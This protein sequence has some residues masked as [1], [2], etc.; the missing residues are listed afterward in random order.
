MKII[1]SV[2][3][4]AI[5]AITSLAVAPTNASSWA[6]VISTWAV[7]RGTSA[8]YEWGWPA[9]FDGSVICTT[10][11]GCIIT[12]GS[13]DPNGSYPHGGINNPNDMNQRVTVSVGSRTV[14]AYE[15]WTRRYGKSGNLTQDP[16]WPLGAR[17]TTTCYGFQ[18]FD[19]V[20]TNYRTGRLLPGTVCGR[21]PEPN[22]RC[23]DLDALVFDFGVMASGQVNG[24]RLLLPRELRCTNTSSVTFRLASTLS[25]SSSL[26]ASLTVNE[27]PLTTSGVTLEVKGGS[28]PLVFTSTLSGTENRGGNYMASSVMIME[29]L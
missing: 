10:P 22:Q 27:K 7:P 29:F 14:D 2:A 24:K 5:L 13:W 9:E 20:D 12:V 16:M 6:T 11:S 3:S 15:A 26:I 23:E 17:L 4:A 8:E 28:T 19:G 25:L 18:V 21:V 1:P